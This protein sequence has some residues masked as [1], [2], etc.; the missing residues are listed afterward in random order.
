MS[1]F[2]LRIEMGNDAMDTADAVACA[3][4]ELAERLRRADAET[5]GSICDANG[6][7]VGEWSYSEEQP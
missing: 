3:L 4:D 6:N 2:T 1:T 7:T 5:S